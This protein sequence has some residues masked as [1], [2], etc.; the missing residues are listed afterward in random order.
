M[1]KNINIVITGVSSGIGKQLV[2]NFLQHPECNVIGIARNQNLLD[3][4]KSEA[5]SVFS[6]HKLHLIAADIS[7]EDGI[8][9]IEATITALFKHVDILIN[10]AGM[11]INKPFSEINFES[12]RKIGRAHV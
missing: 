11:L 6:N 3:K 1:K 10:N 4:L 2:M 5:D 12:W 9:K 8:A 7:T